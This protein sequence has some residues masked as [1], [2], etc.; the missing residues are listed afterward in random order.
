MRLSKNS[1]QSRSELLYNSWRHPWSVELV[2]AGASRCSRAKID[3]EKCS[4][5]FEI[6]RENRQIWNL[7]FS[8]LLSPSPA[9]RVSQKKTMTKVLEARRSWN[10]GQKP[11]APHVK[12]LCDRWGFSFTFSA[13][14]QRFVSFLFIEK[15]LIAA[16]LGWKQMGWEK[17]R[18]LGNFRISSDPS[19][20]IAL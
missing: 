3:S 4:E 10:L 5:L 20:G 11:N 2:P 13:N 1:R 12:R 8:F 17:T 9:G 6:L 14:Q 16:F 18:S 7:N 19:F 15:S